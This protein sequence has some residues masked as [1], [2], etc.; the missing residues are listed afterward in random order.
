MTPEEFAQEMAALRQQRRESLRRVKDDFQ[1]LC[2]MHRRYDIAVMSSLNMRQHVERQF[3]ASAAIL[4]AKFF[5][6]HPEPVVELAN[7]ATDLEIAGPV[8][9]PF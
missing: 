8:Y 5:A 7:E 3:D 2:E 4:A 9:V 1:T 6:E